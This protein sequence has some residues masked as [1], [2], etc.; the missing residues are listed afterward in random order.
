MI[1]LRRLCLLLLAFVPARPARTD[2]LVLQDGKRIE[3]EVV[4]AGDV[5]RITTKYGA[6]TIPKTEVRDRIPS[7]AAAPAPEAPVPPGS[8]PPAAPSP[9][10]LTPPAAPK[11]PP[12]PPGRQD[13]DLIAHY[14]FDGDATD[15][16]GNGHHGTILGA[17]PSPDGKI[18]GAL[19]FNGKAH[20]ALPAAATAGLKRFTFALWMQTS[21]REAP[22][23]PAFWRQPTL[24]GAATSGWGSQD[25]G[26]FVVA[27]RAGYFHGLSPR[28]D[29]FFRSAAV[30]ADNAWHHVA[31]TNDGERVRLYVDGRL[32]AGEHVVFGPPDPPK[33]SRDETTPSGQ[34]LAPHPLFV[35]A[36]AA[37]EVGENVA[38]F[39]EGSIDDVRIWGRAL[40]PAEIAAL[41]NQ[42]SA[43]RVRLPEPDTA[44][45]K[46]AERSIRDRHR[47]EYGKRAAADLLALARTLLDE[48]A[49]A[50]NDAAARYVL[51]REARDL[52]A[53]AGDA[54]EAVRAVDRMA[55][56]FD[57][58][59]LPMKADAMSAAL[60]SVRTPEAAEAFAACALD[61]VEEAVAA[62]RYDTAASLLARAESAARQAQSPA[63]LDQARERRKR[64][65]SLR[66]EYQG[67]RDALKAVEA[68]SNDPGQSLAAGRYLCLSKGDW[69]RG[70]PML[71]RGSDAT[72]KAL[73]E[74]EL[75]RPETPEEQA[76]LGDAWWEA[77]TAKGGSLK[78]RCQDRAADWYERALPAATGLAR[79]R[80]ESRIESARGGAAEGGIPRRGLVF[81]VD[82]GRAGG[83]EPLRELVS[84]ARPSKSTVA[85]APAGVPAIAFARTEVEYPASPAVQAIEREGTIVAWVR[86]DPE[87]TAGGVVDRYEGNHDD[88][89][90]WVYNGRLAEC[91]NWPETS[92]WPPTRFSE[93]RVPSDRWSLAAMTWDAKTLTFYLDG[94]PD[95][96]HPLPAIP[97]RGGTVVNLGSN[98][99]GGREPYLGLIGAVL[100]YNRALRPAEIQSLYQATRSR[101]R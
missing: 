41:V 9:D 54:A 22:P 101:F 52:A 72:L 70:L 58:E 69:D 39:F 34:A 25:V 53:Q 12:T 28:R 84:G 20:V 87:N 71:A 50:R 89:S 14:P 8:R 26:L 86:P 1:P 93:T 64:V 5:Y 68:G 40:A 73:A 2:I 62:D 83:P 63:L 3:G 67:I 44:A 81:W 95:G 4:E 37:R 96:S 46:E 88:V 61:L 99:P 59:A 36:S 56:D 77:G 78:A 27:G 91:I 23:P 33:P 60:R 18:G 19:A 45:Q 29:A 98:P 35:G 48:A 74:Q 94:R 24:L 17:V 6:L 82:P 10:I 51:C 32:A 42:A 97:K 16:S 66:S 79:Q 43:P 31:L 65:E 100:I 90:L 85:P 47:L 49:E 30:L 92:C 15:A 57:V 76:A 80:M 7:G 38:C 21:P 75:A 55:R 13:E 11:S